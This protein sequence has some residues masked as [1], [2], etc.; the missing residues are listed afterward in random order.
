MPLFRPDV[1]DLAAANAYTDAEIV[2]AKAYTDSEILSMS[3]GLTMVKLTQ[4]AYT[5]LGTKDANTVYWIVG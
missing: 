2:D 5:A 4:A 1:S 3:G